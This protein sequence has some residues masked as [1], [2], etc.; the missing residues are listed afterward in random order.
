M[1]IFLTQIYPPQ[2]KADR[3][4]GNPIITISY[5][6][7]EQG[8]VQLKVYNLLGQEIVTLVNEEKPSGKYEALFDASNLSSG[9]YIYTLRVNGFVQNKKM[10]FL[11]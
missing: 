1:L 6:I 11:K 10:S 8:L 4:G 9:V 5:Q 2:P 3:S 7:K